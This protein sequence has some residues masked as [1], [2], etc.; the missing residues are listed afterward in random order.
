MMAGQLEG[1]V[2]LVTGASGGI[3]QQIARVLA[4][5]G[6]TVALVA[7]AATDAAAARLEAAATAIRHGGGAARA[8]PCDVTDEAAVRAMVQRLVGDH[9]RIDVLVNNAA[10]RL[11]TT[12]LDTSAEAFERIFRVN[13]FGPFH[14]WRHVVPIMVRQGRGN[15]IDVVSTNAEREP[16]VGMAPYRATKVALTYL[17]SDLAFEVEALGV[18]V[19]AFDP[20]PIRTAGTAS[21]RASREQRYGS[22]IPYHAQDDVTAIDAAISWL[23]ARSAADFS[24]QVVRRTEFGRTWG[25]GAEIAAKASQASGSA[26]EADGAAAASAEAIA[27]PARRA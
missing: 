19:N 26:T 15:V 4:A 9:G 23:A 10:M 1:R 17:S 20:G 22:G 25:P 2:A 7:R 6:A 8:V 16:F 5:D 21:I 24:G 14:L 11:D 27:A 13:V 12:I 18:A 3:G